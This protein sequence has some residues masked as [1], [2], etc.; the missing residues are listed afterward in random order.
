M[1]FVALDIRTLSFVTTSIS[2][3]FAIGLFAFGFLQKSYRG[4]SLLASA[5]ALFATGHF[6]LGFRDILFD[7]ITII[8]ANLMLIVGIVFY[9][10][11]TRRFLG[12]TGKFHPASPIAI[13]AGILLFVYFTYQVPSVNFRIIGIV[14]IHVVISALCAWE[15]WHTDQQGFWRVPDTI[16]A[17]I[18]AG[19]CFFQLFRLIWTLGENPIQSFMSAGTVHAFAFVSVILLVAGSTFGYIW[20]VSKRFE[21]EL[22]DLATHDPLTNVLNRR[23]FENLAIQEAKKLERGKTE[24]VVVLIDID[25]FKLI[26]DQYGHDYGDAVIAGSAKLLQQ[27]IRPYDVLGRL[28]GDEFILLLPNTQLDEALTIAERL[29]KILENNALMLKETELKVTASFGVAKVPSKFQTLD[30]MI[31]SVDLALYQSKHQGK[32]RVSCFS[33]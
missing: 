17:L 26:N 10:E 3:L 14:T 23:G 11:G 7:F 1:Q 9:F 4:F 2:L 16:T 8:V 29:R 15:L 20:M 18:F 13:F 21:H 19:Y 31:P 25:D 22:V 5:A 6:L 28:G 33:Q 27:S 12:R 30:E 24:L 32:N